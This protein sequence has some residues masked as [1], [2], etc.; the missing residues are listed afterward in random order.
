MF[1]TRLSV[2]TC[3]YEKNNN[4]LAK[5]GYRWA[6]A[7]YLN[8]TEFKIWISRQAAA[9]LRTHPSIKIHIGQQ[10]PICLH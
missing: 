8:H 3:P 4:N 6:M 10:N 1:L 9:P 7:H 5:D 2:H